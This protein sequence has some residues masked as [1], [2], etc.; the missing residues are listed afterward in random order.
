[1]PTR[2]H[3]PD[4]TVG[5]RGADPGAAT[6]PPPPTCSFR[7]TDG[8]PCCLYTHVG[9]RHRVRPPIEGWAA[10]SIDADTFLTVWGSAWAPEEGGR[11]YAIPEAAEARAAHLR[12]RSVPATAETVVVRR[13]RDEGGVF[14]IVDKPLHTHPPAA[15]LPTRGTS[16]PRPP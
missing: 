7:F 5:D 12:A 6:T 16:C 2:T 1:M 15:A 3:A 9:D 14:R 8:A 10:G 11:V 13:V 4:T